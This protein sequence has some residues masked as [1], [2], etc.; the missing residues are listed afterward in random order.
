M[1]G[2]SS[3]VTSVVKTKVPSIFGRL[4][5]ERLDKVAEKTPIM[6]LAEYHTGSTRKEECGSEM[7]FSVGY[8]LL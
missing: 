7:T 5:M 4:R 8:D 6:I 3:R 2:C 1:E